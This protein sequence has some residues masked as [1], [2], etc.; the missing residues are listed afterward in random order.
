M[1]QSIEEMK[2]TMEKVLEAI[3]SGVREYVDDHDDSTETLQGYVIVSDNNICPIFMGTHFSLNPLY[4]DK[5]TNKLYLS[6]MS[7]AGVVNTRNKDIEE[8]VAEYNEQADAS[9]KFIE[10]PKKITGWV[11]F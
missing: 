2:T 8:A 1:K 7:I 3:E 10:N 6:R 4:F 11:K 9:A 5:G